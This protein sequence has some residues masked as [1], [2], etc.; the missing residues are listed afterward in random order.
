MNL[1]TTRQLALVQAKAKA[2]DEAAR[3]FTELSDIEAHRKLK[4]ELAAYVAERHVAG[5]V[6]TDPA[7]FVVEELERIERS[8][9]RAEVLIEEVMKAGH[10]V[11][12]PAGASLTR[13]ALQAAKEELDKVAFALP[14]RR[15]KLAPEFVDDDWKTVPR[16]T[17]LCPEVLE[18]CA[19]RRPQSPVLAKRRVDLYEFAQGRGALQEQ[20]AQQLDAGRKKCGDLLGLHEQQRAIIEQVGALAAAGNFQAAAKLLEPLK[21]LFGDLHYQHV[22]EAI[23]Q[24]K[25]PLLDLEEKFR[26]LKERV[27]EPVKLPFAQPWKVALHRL[28]MEEQFNQMLHRLTHLSQEMETKPTSDFTAQG[29][30]LFKTIS[31]ALPELQ[32]EVERKGDAARVAGVVQMACAIVGVLALGKLVLQLVVLGVVFGAALALAGIG[33]VLHRALLARTAVEFQFEVNGKLLTDGLQAQIFLNDQP[34]RAGAHLVPG[35][36]RLTV[37]KSVYEPFES[38]V[39]IAYGRRNHLGTLKLVLARENY[40]NSLGMVFVPV[41]GTS[42]LFGVWPARVQDYEAYLK[43]NGLPIPKPPFFQKWNHPAVNITYDDANAYCRWLTEV[44]RKSGKLGEKHLYR[45]PTDLEW[46]A[47][48]GLGKEPGA[49]PAERD[50]RTPGVFPWGTQWPPPRGA[51]NYDPMI[52]TDDFD[53]TSPVGSFAPNHFGLYDLGG[54]VW[55]WCADFFDNT[56]TGRVLRGGSWHSGNAERMLSSFRLFNS[57]GHRAT[58]IGLRCVLEGKRLGAAPTSLQNKN[59]GKIP[60]PSETKPASVPS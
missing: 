10:S 2:L 59:T 46:S 15:Q 43:A 14:G 34:T 6:P 12:H 30:P 51:G 57:P 28:A 8:L 58:S 54:N 39:V 50:S 9:A 53:Y 45:L 42:V 23:D 27:A 48:V 3:A 44:E 52:R 37:D 18:F 7:A 19:V 22:Q 41:P 56:Q 55:E 24:W 31:Q 35:T 20:V 32:A 4:R 25:K 36:Y 16:K 40:I 1:T 47:A 13:E 21:Q 60:P 17:D 33:A 38:R 26:K 5:E 29:R 49:T 11:L